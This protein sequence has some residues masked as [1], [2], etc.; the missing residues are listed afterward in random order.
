MNCEDHGHVERESSMVQWSMPDPSNY[1]VMKIW[2]M[3]LLWG[4][5]YYHTY[6]YMWRFPEIG[7]PLNHPFIDLFSILNHPAIRGTPI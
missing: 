7:V 1:P 3:I 5:Q 4:G 2:L 6:I